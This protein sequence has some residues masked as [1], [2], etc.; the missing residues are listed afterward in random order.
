MIIGY[1]RVSSKS[2]H[3][4]IQLDKLN[5]YG[6]EKIFMDKM[7]G[8]TDIRTG[9]KSMVEFIRAGDTLV[10]TRLDRL[11]RNL[12]DLT[13]LMYKFDNENINL[14]VIDQPAIN[15]TTSEGKKVY[16]FFSVLAEMELHN[17]RERIVE[18]V[19]KAKAKGVKFGR[20]EKVTKEQKYEIRTMRRNGTPIKDLMRTFDLSKDTIYRIMRETNKLAI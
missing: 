16:E 18:G 5:D 10:V 11:S 12:R 15:T 4:E 17:N 1:A 3:L 9:Y 20:P 14:V 13:Y 7:S 2:Q 6:C 8:S 19:K